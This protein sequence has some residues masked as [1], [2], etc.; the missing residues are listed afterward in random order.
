MLTVVK[1]ID[2]NKAICVC[3]IC[4]NDYLVKYKSDARKSPLGE[5]CNDCKMFRQNMEIT[6]ENLRKAFDY[7]PSTGTFTHKLPR[8]GGA[9]GDSALTVHNGGYAAVNVGGSTYL[10][11]RLIYLYMTGR[12]P[13]IVDHINHNRKDNRWVNLREVDDLDNAKNITLQKNSVSKINGVAYHKPTGRYRAYI[14]INY[15]QKHLGLFDT[16][17]EAIQARN[18]ANIKYNYHSNH[19]SVQGSE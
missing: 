18:Q 16:L 11:H 10:A 1:D 2:K 6:Q 15:K 14:G 7:N 3:S 13:K 5:Y 17:E 8:R 9:I 4:K 19:G 12:L